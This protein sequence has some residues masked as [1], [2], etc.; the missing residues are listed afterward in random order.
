MKEHRFEPWTIE[1][2]LDAAPDHLES[3]RTAIREGVKILNGTDIPPGEK[4]EGVNIVV[5]ECEH[6]VEAG[7]SPLG[8]MQTCTTNPAELMKLDKQRDL[9]R[10]AIWESDP[11]RSRVKSPAC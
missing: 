10:D 6:L 8:S 4:D 7:L 3:A 2:A 5:R 1:K 11:P 9:F